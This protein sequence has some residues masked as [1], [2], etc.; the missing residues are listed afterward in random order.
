MIERDRQQRNADRLTEC[1][2]P[3][4]AAVQSVIDHLE[5]DHFRPRIQDGYRSPAEQ[6]VAYQAGASKLRYGFHNVTGVR[7]APES[8]AVD[9]I[10]DD[11]PM[12]SSAGYCVA[13][14]A[15][16]RALGLHT[17]ILWGL[18]ESLHRPLELAIDRRDWSGDGIRLGWDPTHLEPLGITPEQ[19]RIGQRPVHLHGGTP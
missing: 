18:P 17:G 19:A 3:F 12:A 11:H 1:W 6:L 14:A 9:L 7:G 4:A 10:D 5:R 8:L 2:P 16:S 15:A 13:L